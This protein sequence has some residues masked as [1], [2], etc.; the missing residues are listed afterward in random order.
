[1]CDEARRDHRVRAARR[2]AGVVLTVGSRAAGR[3]AGRRGEAVLVQVQET[4]HGVGDIETGGIRVLEEEAVSVVD[5]WG[6][7]DVALRSEASAALA[8]A[9]E[10]DVPV[11]IDTSKV[12]FMDSTGIAFLVQFYT[13]GAEEGLSVTLRNPPPVVTD[14][15]HMLGV[16]A[17][18]GADRHEVTTA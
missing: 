14:V 15:L 3:G 4:V 16:D 9:L 11:V 17:I 2:A 8:N 13:I 12:T 7:I 10:R 6:E 1:M 18:F 5:M